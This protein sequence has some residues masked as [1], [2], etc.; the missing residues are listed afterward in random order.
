MIHLHRPIQPSRNQITD[1][2]TLPLLSD[3]TH[4]GQVPWFHSFI[5]RCGPNMW[6]LL[7]RQSL[8][9]TSHDPVISTRSITPSLLRSL[10]WSYLWLGR[11]RM[12]GGGSCWKCAL[13]MLSI[14]TCGVENKCLEDVRQRDD[15]HDA[16]IL[17]HHHQSVHLS[18]DYPIYYRF[19][20]LKSVAFH[21]PFKVL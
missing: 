4:L 14:D 16:A 1:Q 6:S 10:S 9:A 13:G 17:I 19:Q 18:L 12:G 11:E 15:A 7:P 5:L 20:C 2:I 8:P 3:S 21:D